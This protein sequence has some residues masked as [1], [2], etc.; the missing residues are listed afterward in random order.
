M[1]RKDSLVD[2]QQPPTR[3][4]VI[5]DDPVS[6]AAMQHILST[7]ADMDVV[8]A[9]SADRALELVA[10]TTFDV[11]V[12]DVQMP[13][14]TGLEL[15]AKLDTAAPGLPVV[16]V[17]GEPSADNRLEVLRSRAAAFTFKPVRPDKLVASVTQ[18]LHPPAVVE[19][20]AS[21][22]RRRLFRR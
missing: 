1:N 8:T 12:S 4:L 17:T 13:G 21:A 7:H 14:T 2:H 20:P 11:V 18:A 3:V 16:L 15:L 22:P 6:R 9:A 19:P 5:D 10:T